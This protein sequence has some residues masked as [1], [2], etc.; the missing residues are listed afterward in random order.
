MI[1]EAMSERVNRWR[2]HFI[3]YETSPEIDDYF[4]GKGVLC[5]Q[6]QFGQDSFPA[7]A[8]FRGIEFNSYRAC[9]ALLMGWN[10]KHFAFCL[11][12]LRK[13]AELDARNLSTVFHRRGD[14][15]DWV[16]DAFGLDKQTWTTAL[17]VL[18][19]DRANLGYHTETVCGPAA[20]LIR[21]G[22]D[23]VLQPL[24][25]TAMNPF[26]FLLR[27]LR[28]RFRDDWDRNVNER[29][30]AYRAQLYQLFPQECM[31]KTPGNTRLRSG[32]ATKTDVDAAVLDRRTGAIGLFQL[33]W[34]DPFGFSMRERASRS[35]NFI[36]E[37]KKSVE[38]TSQWLET[39][40]ADE[41]LANFGFGRS[42]KTGV[43]PIRLFV[44]GRNF[45]HFSG[46]DEMDD[47]AAWGTWP[48]LLRHAHDHYRHDDPIEGL[49]HTL[50]ADSPTDRKVDGLQRRAFRLGD[51]SIVWDPCVGDEPA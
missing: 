1:G 46:G 9:L 32:G 43:K 34:Q 25:G 33:K 12:L 36:D 8:N 38:A 7:E 10:L 26:F 24:F 48:Q 14:M 41:I 49:Y 2:Q 15:A 50:R 29:E 42:S 16:A 35:R 21:I 45:A 28:N 19:L 37:S 30:S 27:E 23:H 40:D 4:E 11:E 13:H 20:P 51:K 3:K 17:D 44:L 6:L 39:H 31:L 18:T 47:R 5:A 22:A